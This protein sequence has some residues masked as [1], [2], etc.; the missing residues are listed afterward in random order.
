MLPNVV[1]CKLPLTPDM[2]T[3]WYRSPVIFLTNDDYS[4]A[5]D[6]W[7][8][9]IVLV[10]MSMG[11]P[12]FRNASEFG[13]L[14]SIFKVLGTPSPDLWQS[15]LGA[16]AMKGIMGTCPF[17]QL[18]PQSPFPFGTT[19]GDNFVVLI[20]GFIAGEPTEPN[21]CTAS[22]EELLVARLAMQRSHWR[23]LTRGF[24]RW[25]ASTLRTITLAYS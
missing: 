8:Y 13:M 5:S 11:V 22:H 7:S 10:E 21:D 25:F 18:Q 17:P 1:E 6:M 16:P 12:P 24:N 4:Y 9:G 3:I 15:L 20:R 14:S 2:T 23:F 19:Y